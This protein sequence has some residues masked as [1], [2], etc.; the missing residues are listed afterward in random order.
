MFNTE[1]NNNQ[2]VFKNKK[3]KKR[4]IF[5]DTISN[6]VTSHVFKSKIILIINIYQHYHSI[7]V[8]L[9]KSYLLLI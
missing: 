2:N 8:S 1:K 6:K 5:D 7:L 3:K 4:K 9:N